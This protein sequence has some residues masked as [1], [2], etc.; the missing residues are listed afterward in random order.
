[1]LI[2]AYD[3]AASLVACCSPWVQGSKYWMEKKP[4]VYFHS[5]LEFFP[6]PLSVLNCLY[7]NPNDQ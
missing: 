6:I 4:K 5:L 2:P 7:L 3:I 1:M